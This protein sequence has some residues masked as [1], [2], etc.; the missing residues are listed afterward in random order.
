MNGHFRGNT[1]AKIQLAQVV[2]LTDVDAALQDVEAA[3]STETANLLRAV[4]RGFQLL[5][6][7]AH[8]DT[9]IVNGMDESG[10][11]C[12]FLVIRFPDGSENAHASG[13]P[14]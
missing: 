13:S 5:S 2:T 3:C 1:M 6:E 9:Q 10:K 7:G 8:L 11:Q 12:L 14:M 4:F